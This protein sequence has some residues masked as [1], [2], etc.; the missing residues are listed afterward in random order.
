M[1]RTGHYSL[2]GKSARGDML[3]ARDGSGEKHFQRRTESDL[4]ID[5]GLFS[6]AEVH[7]LLDDWL[8]PAIVDNLIRDVVNSPSL[9]QPERQTK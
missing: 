9:P 4:E 1:D 8:V 3:L 5:G 2:F 7:G 6:D